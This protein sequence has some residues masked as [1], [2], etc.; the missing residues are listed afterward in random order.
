MV[1]YWLTSDLA[2]EETATSFSVNNVD[3]WWSVSSYGGFLL[4]TMSCAVI[5]GPL[6]QKAIRRVNFTQPKF[7]NRVICPRWFLIVWN[8]TSW[9]WKMQ[10]RQY[11]SISLVKYV[12]RKL[13]KDIVNYHV[14]QNMDTDSSDRYMLLVY[15]VWL[16]LVHF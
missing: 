4:T 7:R 6:L 14:R 2:I 11:G 15:L 8:R 1:E 12:E 3:H 13:E 10:E 9:I 16:L 5:L